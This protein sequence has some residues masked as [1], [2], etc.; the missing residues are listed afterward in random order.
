MTEL[1]RQLDRKP[2]YH[3]FNQLTGKQ[4]EQ[5]VDLLPDTHQTM[6]PALC[7]TAENI[8]VVWCWKCADTGVIAEHWGPDEGCK[9]YMTE[10]E[11]EFC[12]CDE[13]FMAKEADYDRRE[14][15]RLMIEEHDEAQKI[16]FGSLR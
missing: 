14:T 16:T 13:G 11:V 7:Y 9:E 10:P 6:I 12:D 4:S 5:I 8:Q 3:Y 15:E 1:E 2:T